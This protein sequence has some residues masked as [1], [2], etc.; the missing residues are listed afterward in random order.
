MITEQFNIRV[1]PATKAKIIHNARVVGQRPAE[2]AR[3]L[4]EKDEELITGQELHRRLARNLKKYR[5]ALAF[6]Q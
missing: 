6:A 2:Y 4:L 3:A 1:T 5:G